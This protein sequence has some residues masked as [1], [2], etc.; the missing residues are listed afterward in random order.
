MDKPNVEKTKDKVA[1]R[2][3]EYTRLL[4]RFECP[5]AFRR[6]LRAARDYANTIKEARNGR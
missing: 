4:G 6:L 1:Q 5:A 3:N 2:A